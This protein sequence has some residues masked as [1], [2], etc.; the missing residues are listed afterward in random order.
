MRA[1]GWRVHAPRGPSLPRLTQHTPPSPLPSPARC[2]ASRTT[3]LAIYPARGTGARWWMPAARAT[4]TSSATRCACACQP[5]G[6]GAP[7]ARPPEPPA[8]AHPAPIRHPTHPPTHPAPLLP[9]PVN[10]AGT[11]L[12]SWTPTTACPPPLTFTSPPSPS[13]ASARRSASQASASAGWPATTR[14]VS[15]GGEG[16]EGVNACAS[17]SPAPGSPSPLLLRI[18][19]PPA[20]PPTH[21][22]ARPP[23]HPPTPSLTHPPPQPPSPAPR[24]GAQG[25]HN[26]LLL[27][28][29]RGAGAGG[30]AAVGGAGWEA[31]GPHPRKPGGGGRV[32]RAVGARVPLVSGGRGGGGGGGGGVGRGGR[33]MQ[34]S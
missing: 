5:P 34:S 10:R 11:A 8:A 1:G 26:H 7:P 29:L 25:L 24:A 23:I 18:L 12:L 3:P 13:A 27:C 33:R 2:A 31:A 22:P 9:P 20:H 14:R 6:L 4:R 15:R 28:P 32:F 16:R 19:P 17:F 21:P 30:G